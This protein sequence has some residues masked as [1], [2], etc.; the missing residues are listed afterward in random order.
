VRREPALRLLDEESAS[1]EFRISDRDV[2]LVTGGG[3][4]I[5]A[6]CALDLARTMG[7]SLILMGR[8]TPESDTELTKNLDR[9]RQFGVTFRY[10]TADLTNLPQVRSALVQAES[11][12]GPITGIVHGAG[13]NTPAL[14]HSLTDSAFASTVAVKVEGLRNVLGCVRSSEL[15][16]VVAFGSL[17]A[18]TGLTG[19]A[20]YA[21]ANEW[22]RMLVDRYQIEHPSC[23]CLTIEWSVWSGAGMGQRLGRIEALAAQGITAMSPDEGLAAFRH[24]VSHR[25]PV[26]SAVVTGRFGDPLTLKIDNPELPLRRFLERPRYFARGVELVVDVEI[27]HETDPYLSDHVFDKTPVLPGVM[28]LEAMA[29]VGTALLETNEPPMFESIIFERAIPVGDKPVVLR[30]AALIR[31]PGSCEI[32][33][34][35][36]ETA[37]Q[38]DHVRATC[39]QQPTAAMALPAVSAY[40]PPSLRPDDLYG[41]ILFHGRRFRRLRSYDHLRATECVTEIYCMQDDWFGAFL[42]QT[43]LLGDPGARDA[44]I[45]GIQACIPQSTLLPVSV[46]RIFSGN[47]K[48]VTRVQGYARETRQDGDCF[49]YDL[50]IASAEGVIIERW[51]GLRLKKVCDSG[52]RGGWVE[53]LLG[54]YIERRLREVISRDELPAVTVGLA[55]THDTK[56]THRPD[57]KR[58]GRVS[59]SHGGGI[60]LAIAGPD[61]AG[62]D[63]EPV[64]PRSV[65]LW[66]DLLGFDRFQLAEFIHTEAREDLETA[67][68]RVWTAYECLKKAGR[69]PDAPLV[70]ARRHD[71]N[72]IVLT[73]GTVTI[74]TLLEQVRSSTAPIVIAVLV[75]HARHP[76]QIAH[77][78]L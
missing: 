36:S 69:G 14:I 37:F 66:R 60:S 48:G 78:S 67:A 75:S 6:E 56:P 28:A 76:V 50:D 43:L 53:G 64:V 32:T 22:L 18:R 8:S 25:L 11:E 35:S 20:D 54:P 26:S 13:I 12:L 27:S 41:G 1:L 73:S 70:F 62:C 52:V 17:I 3:K 31:A 51:Q 30:I 65:G 44:A 19:E 61:S 9:F 21:I 58:D 59:A 5:A 77:A 33:I 74:M 23:N 16:L 40:R 55:A 24:L 57:G 47:V 46:D 49:I 4:G 71:D 38:V 34:R 7:V 42:P 63:V 10:V 45:H 2:V 39:R 15:R 68:T 29:Q 72:C